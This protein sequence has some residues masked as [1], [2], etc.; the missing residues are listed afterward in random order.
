MSV[1]V[2]L[3][4]FT[5]V[6]MAVV[7]ALSIAAVR[8]SRENTRR[9]VHYVGIAALAGAGIIG[10]AA[11]TQAS[12]M[13]VSGRMLKMVVPVRGVGA[14]QAEGVDADLH[15]GWYSLATVESDSLG[16]GV[17]IIGA[18]GEC[19][20][21]VAL[22]IVCLA[23]WS[24]CRKLRS[25]APFDHGLYRI[26]IIAAVVVILSGMAGQVLSG[27]SLTAAAAQL[28]PN[29]PDSEGSSAHV[30]IWDVWTGVSLWPVAVGLTLMVFATLVRLGRLVESERSDLREQVRGLV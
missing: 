21:G 23:V 28:F 8:S 20:T 18:L 16:F 26:S 12:A 4:A 10:I 22:V 1:P 29:G 25:D 14:D 5:V 15:S 27:V 30:P 11:V 19:F 17:R 7:V 2:L 6:V 9:G 13:L 3:I 24:V